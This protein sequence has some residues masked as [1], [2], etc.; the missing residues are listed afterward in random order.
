[1]NEVNDLPIPDE[2]TS[3]KARADLMGLPYHVNIGVDKLREKVNAQLTDT[4]LVPEVKL[5]ALAAIKDSPISLGGTIEEIIEGY[6]ANVNANLSTAQKRNNAIKES[7]RLVRIQ[8]TC[9]NPVKRDWPGETIEVSN[10]VVG[11]FKKFIPFNNPAGYHV[12]YII[13]QALKEREC[14]IFVNGADFRGTPTKRAKLIKEFSVEI[15][16]PLTQAEIKELAQRQ[17]MANGSQE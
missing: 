16:E 6:H 12:P 17:L 13:F 3:L 10:S 4:P 5:E 14:Q 8:V 7:N 2:L 1:M 9:M 15:M 11:S